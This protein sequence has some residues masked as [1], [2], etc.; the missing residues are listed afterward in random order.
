MALLLP[1]CDRVTVFA[2]GEILA[3]GTSDEILTRA[4]VRAAYFGADVV[5]G[6]P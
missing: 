3:D 1:L 5:A 6:N 2:S 4:D